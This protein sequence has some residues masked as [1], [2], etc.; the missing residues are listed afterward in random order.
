MLGLLLFQVY[1]LY[2]CIYFISVDFFDLITDIQFDNSI[3]IIIVILSNYIN[4]NTDWYIPLILYCRHLAF[5]IKISLFYLFNHLVQH[6]DCS[7]R[8]SKFTASIYSF[9]LACA[10]SPPLGLQ[11][12]SFP[13]KLD[14][15]F[16]YS[17]HR[18]C[19]NW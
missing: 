9:A 3:I 17:H 7:I 18:Y 4:Y 1:G 2:M 13:A 12:A 6:N 11:T 5:K 15:F 19:Q 10:L 14:N 16:H 8:Y